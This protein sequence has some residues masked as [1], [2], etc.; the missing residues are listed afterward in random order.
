M[1][2]EAAVDLVA[3]NAVVARQAAV[4]ELVA[5]LAVGL[6][7]AVIELVADLA[8]GLLVAAIELVAD[9]AVG[10]L[11]AAIEPVAAS[12][13]GLPVPAAAGRHW[14]ATVTVALTRTKSIRCP[15]RC[16]S[17]CNHAESPFARALQWTTSETRCENNSVGPARGVAVRAVPGLAAATILGPPIVDRIPHRVPFGLVPKIE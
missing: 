15:I 7:A 9:L 14:T 3:L 11:V 10:L 17:L 13:V 16:G 1:V 5:D 6:Q 8:V 2:D 4:I 12:A